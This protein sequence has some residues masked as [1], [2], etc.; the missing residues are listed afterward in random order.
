MS[1]GRA[2]GSVEAVFREERGRLLAM[3]VRQFPAAV[4]RS[5]GLMLTWA[6]FSASANVAADTSGPVAGP[7]P[8]AGGM[9]AVGSSAVFCGSVRHATA[10]PNKPK[11][12]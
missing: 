10:A 7:V 4:A 2:A 12:V 11:D 5:A 8:N 1:G 3:L 9:P 6:S